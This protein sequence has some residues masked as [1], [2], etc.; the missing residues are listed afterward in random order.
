MS[1]MLLSITIWLRKYQGREGNYYTIGNAATLLCIMEMLYL[2]LIRDFFYERYIYLI[3]KDFTGIS[4]ILF[5][6]GFLV[7]RVHYLMYLL[8]SKKIHLHYKAHKRNIIKITFMGIVL[9]I[10]VFFKIVKF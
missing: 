2:F 3:S 7:F 6:I 4:I 8:K 10:T 9:A 1:K 5:T